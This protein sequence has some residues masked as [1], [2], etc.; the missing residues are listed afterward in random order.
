M[1]ALVAIKLTNTKF[2]LALDLFILLLQK[3]YFFYIV[4]VADFHFHDL[5]ALRF[6]VNVSYFSF[7]V[8]SEGHIFKLC[9]NKDNHDF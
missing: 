5:K 4:F 8:C 3:T 1:C 9:L 2:A 7:V 6:D